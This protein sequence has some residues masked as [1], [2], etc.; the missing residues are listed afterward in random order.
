MLSVDSNPM[1]LFE[2]A[3]SA[4]IA[5][6]PVIAV[7]AARAVAMLLLFIVVILPSIEKWPSHE[8]GTQ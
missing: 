6:N 3:A 5:A 7:A 2:G 8:R 1:L 4:G